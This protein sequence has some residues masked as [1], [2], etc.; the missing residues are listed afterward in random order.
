MAAR[1]ACKLLG[2]SD[3]MP[4]TSRR[5]PISEHP[6]WNPMTD[7]PRW[8]GFDREE[9][10]REREREFREREERNRNRPPPHRPYNP[11][12]G[13]DFDFEAFARDFVYGDRKTRNDPRIKKCIHCRKVMTTAAEI[14][15]KICAEC[16]RK[17]KEKY[18]Q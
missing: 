6:H 10:A 9:R 12:D 2:E 4:S 17:E 14:A 3:F 8:S 7:P 5:P 15:N 1:K 11:F 16:W 18:G 13:G